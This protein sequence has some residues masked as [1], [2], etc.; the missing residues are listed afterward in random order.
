MLALSHHARGIVRRGDPTLTSSRALS[1]RNV[2]FSSSQASSRAPVGARSSA[3]KD[4]RRLGRLVGILAGVGERLLTRGFRILGTGR[5]RCRAASKPSADEVIDEE[6]RQNVSIEPS[7]GFAYLQ[8]QGFVR[9]LVDAA[10]PGGQRGLG[11]RPRGGGRAFRS[12][13]VRARARPFGG[14]RRSVHDGLR[15]NLRR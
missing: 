7:A 12:G 14:E 15:A 4:V 6:L 13:G 9:G 3:G 1:I 11:G 5:T 8:A 10:A 2:L